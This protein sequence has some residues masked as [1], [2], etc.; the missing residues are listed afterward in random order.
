VNPSS[1][2]PWERM[3]LAY[4]SNCASV[5][6]DEPER[7]EAAAALDWV[8][9]VLAL[10]GLATPLCAAALWL[11]TVSGPIARAPGTLQATMPGVAW[12]PMRNTCPGQ[13]KRP[14]TRCRYLEGG[15]WRP[16]SGHRCP[17]SLVSYEPSQA[18]TCARKPHTESGGA[19]TRDSSGLGLSQPFGPHKEDR[20][21]G[22]R[23]KVAEGLVRAPDKC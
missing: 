13:G 14:R 18:T 5:G 17:T 10:P 21:P 19:D 4:F 23:W 12:P 9:V 7:L 6:P 1:K 16:R 15:N 2:L 8:V 22:V 20:F 11:S 3:H